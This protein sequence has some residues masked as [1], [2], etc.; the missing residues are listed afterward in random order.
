MI[1]GQPFSLECII[2]TVRGVNSQINII[3][4]KVSNGEE[5]KR[6]NV[7]AYMIVNSSVMYRDYLNISQLTTDDNGETYR[8]EVIIN[9][10]PPVKA[11]DSYTLYV[12]GKNLQQYYYATYAYVCTFVLT[13]PSFSITTTPS[14]LIRGA[15]VGDNQIIHCTISTVN[16]VKLNAVTVDWI[17]PGGASISRNMISLPALSSSNNFT[18]NF[19]SSLEF[20]Y[21]R[22]VDEGRYMCNVSI[23][24]VSESIIIE[25]GTL[26]GK[27]QMHIFSIIRICKL[28]LLL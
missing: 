5:L 24:Q 14:G 8:C 4:S 18:N 27:F 20:M 17:G 26:I 16:G 13:A 9:T 10:S 1:V 19:S 15:V 25:L 11:S 3:W 23:L 21:L 28:L 22:E 12:T 7:S 6:E 2:T